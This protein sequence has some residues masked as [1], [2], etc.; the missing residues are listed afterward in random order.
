MMLSN[1]VKEHSVKYLLVSF[2][3]LFG[4]MRSKLIPVSALDQ[5]ETSG[6][7]FAGFAA[8]FDLTPADPDVIVR[9]D[10]STFKVLP[11][12]RDVA[13]VTGD[14]YMGGTLLEQAP[15]NVLKKCIKRA[16]DFGVRLKTGVEAEFF[17]L[18]E[19]GTQI[20]DPKDRQAKPC[21]DQLALMR[22][23]DVIREICDSI[24]SFGWH[25]YQ[26]DHEDA[27]G[28]FEINWAFSD[29]L[30]TADRHAF[31]KFLVRSIAEKYGYRASFMP[32]PY[33]HLTGNGCHAHCSLWDNDDQN[34]FP[35]AKSRSGL[36]EVGERFIAGLM[37]HAPALCALTNP[38]VNSYKR[39][40]ARVTDSGATWSP[41]SISYAGN[42]RSHLIRIPDGDRC[43]LRLAD[44]ATNPY[45]LQAGILAAGIIGIRDHLDPGPRSDTNAYIQREATSHQL[46]VDLPSALCNLEENHELKELLGSHFINSY[47]KLRRQELCSYMRSV[48][49][50]ERIHTLDC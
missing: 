10:A 3:D 9:P 45:L 27:N 17:L 36:S 1:L 32:K 33:A 48:S 35:L 30:E 20:G 19:D 31:F 26:N 25:P 8:H 14:I 22:R 23:Y 46:P 2:T 21:Y 12:R 16:Q 6:A 5:L 7:A 49:E 15:R 47:L 29:T 11:W 24:E 38:T 34:L 37:H 41:S 42:N 28:Q 13:W 4:V 43:E 50:W 18:T 40:N 44:G 39:L